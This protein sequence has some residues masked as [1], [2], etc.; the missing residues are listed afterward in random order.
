[1]TVRID[2]LTRIWANS[3]SDYVGLGLNVF[4]GT[5]GANSKIARFAINNEEIF[6]IDTQGNINVAGKWSSNTLY[7]NNVFSNNIYEI[8]RAHV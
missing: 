7:S 8:G 5:Y 3:S 4:A 2:N 6:V 1:M